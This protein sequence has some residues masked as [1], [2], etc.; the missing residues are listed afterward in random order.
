M[1]VEYRPLREGNLSDLV[2]CPGGL[3]LAG[4]S[5]AGRLELVADWHRDRLRE[6][7][8]GRVA[9]AEGVPRGFVEYAATEI[10]PFPIEAPGACVLLCFHWAGTEPEDSQHLVE[11]RRMIEAAIADARPAFIGMAALGWNH[12]TH[13]PI[14]LLR[15]L[16]FR[17]IIRDEPI[18]LLWLPFRAG[19]A[20][21][22]L[23]RPQFRPRN[24]RSRGLLAVDQAW[25]ARCP[26]SIHFAERMRSV[27]D[28]HPDRRQIDLRQYRIDTRDETFRLAASPWDWG[29]TYLNGEEI[30]LFQYG[31]DKL[32]E[33]IARRVAL[34]RGSSAS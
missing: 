26:Y 21:P 16:G 3:E 23:A 13:Y 12:P 6:G 28:A 19:S 20:T 5:F 1:P 24:L 18:A 4:K 7:M 29:W 34:L 14:T 30:S 27:V 33:E 10:A 9:Y 22:T 8:R 25:S 31:A 32:R 2:C 15:E 17:E 11:E